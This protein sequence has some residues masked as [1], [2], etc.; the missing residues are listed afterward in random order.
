MCCTLVFFE[1][2]QNLIYKFF[3]LQ[4]LK[5]GMVGAITIHGFDN[6]QRFFCTSSTSQ[7]RVDTVLVW[8]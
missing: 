6:N 2:R 8:L 1:I 3:N 5:A 4:N 7:K